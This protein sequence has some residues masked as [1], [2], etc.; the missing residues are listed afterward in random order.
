ME[1][2]SEP[3]GEIRNLSGSFTHTARRRPGTGTLAVQRTPRRDSG[4]P[5][6]TRIA[7]A[8]HPRPRRNS[9]ALARG[10]VA[11][12]FDQLKNEG[13][14]E[15]MV[16]AG[17][18]VAARLPDESVPVQSGSARS[19]GGTIQGRTLTARPGR[20]GWS[21][22][23]A[24]LAF[25]RQGIPQL[26]AR[27]RLFPVALWSRV[28]GRVLRNAP[29]SLYGQGDARGYLP[30]QKS[31]RGIYRTGPRRA[32]RRRSDHRS[33]RARNR[34]STLWPACSSIPAMRSG[35]KIPAIPAPCLLFAPRAPESSRCR[36]IRKD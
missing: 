24:G 35:W 26:R 32:L 19:R 3:H 20:R 33:P 27:D 6:E 5:L 7:H 13:Y 14:I 2:Q 28:A 8:I 10:T 36:S 34:G 11:A 15:A 21:A 17:T 4:W 1:M 25:R 9:T 18:F 29:R 22:P 31:H 16:G 30:L 23:A 12:A